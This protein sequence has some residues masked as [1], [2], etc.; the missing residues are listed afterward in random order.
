MNHRIN[1]LKLAMLLP[2]IGIFILLSCSK[3]NSID[4]PI[5][6]QPVRGEITQIS[7]I[8]NFSKTDIQQMLDYQ[9]IVVPFQLN[10]DVK[11][12]SVVYTSI[13][14]TGKTIDVSGA[15]IIPL[16]TNNIPLLSLQHGTESKKGLVA[17]ESALKS[18]E[19]IIGLITASMGYF[20]II[21]DY[22]GF[23]QSNTTHPYLHAAS[24]IPNVID[25]IFAGNSYC[26][27]NEITLNHQIF[28]TGYSEGGFVTLATQKTIE[29]EYSN[30]FSIT[31][32]APLSGP[33]DL[34]G[35]CDSIFLS[36]S[37]PSPAYVAYFLTAYNN[38]YGWQS[39]D[40]FFKPQYVSLMPTLFDGSK[41]WGTI[42]NLL[43]PT[44]TE[45]MNESFLSSYLNGDEPAFEKALED[46]TTL[47][48][49]PMAPLH[50]FHGDA[51]KTV[52]YQN[53]L[54]AVDRLK[55]NGAQNILN[56]TIPGVNHETAGPLAIFGAL[57]WFESYRSDS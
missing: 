20:T 17:S 34:K 50:F 31:A 41:E 54:T 2:L 33:Y 7:T 1:Y 53:M 28:L 4:P 21:P 22:S 35:M 6:Q 47:D 29:D 39:L 11:V 38:V 36:S 48:W 51:D 43:P 25:F 16:G 10:Y 3:E 52:P 45:L 14:E 30:E 26:T 49:L 23:G 57:N 44:I 18:T 56:T 55:A 5:I 9:N 12:M 42:V 24:L 37:Y 19:G 15:F 32:V 13:D 8:E 40:K 27:M 46:N